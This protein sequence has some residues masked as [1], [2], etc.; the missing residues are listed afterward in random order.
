MCYNIA[1]SCEMRT[2]FLK[3]KGRFVVAVHVASVTRYY[4]QRLVPVRELVHA[5][6]AHYSHM[7]KPDLNTDEY[8]I[9]EFLS[10]VKLAQSRG[11][12]ESKFGVE[13]M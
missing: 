13:N 10:P 2:D 5:K 7:I 6:H 11:K 9:A 12:W 1:R 4:F 8:K 3:R